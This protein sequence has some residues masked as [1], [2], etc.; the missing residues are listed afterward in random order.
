MLLQAADVGDGVF[1]GLPVRLH[2]GDLL[3]EIGEVFLGQSPMRILE[4]PVA[5]EEATNRPL[6]QGA[7]FVV[8]KLSCLGEKLRHK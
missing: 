3:V 8:I 1:L 2:T 5:R 7:T 6:Q 4:L